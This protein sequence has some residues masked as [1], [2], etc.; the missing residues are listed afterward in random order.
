MSNVESLKLRVEGKKLYINDIAYKGTKFLAY[1]QTK[2]RK[3][4]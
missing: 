3:L 1:V 4:L 2:R